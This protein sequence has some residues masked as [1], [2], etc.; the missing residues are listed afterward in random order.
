MRRVPRSAWGIAKA[1]LA[2]STKAQ[3]GVAEPDGVER[4]ALI[5]LEAVVPAGSGVAS[6]IAPSVTSISSMSVC[7]GSTASSGTA[8]ETKKSGV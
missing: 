5:P 3:V 1:S 7:W 8:D 2:A 4:S 6:R